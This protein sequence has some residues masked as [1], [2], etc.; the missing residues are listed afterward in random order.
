MA[1]RLKLHLAFPDKSGGMPLVTECGREIT[2][3]VAVKVAMD[4]MDPEAKKGVDCFWCR[5]GRAR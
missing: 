1:N 4:R 5:W 3:K 2:G